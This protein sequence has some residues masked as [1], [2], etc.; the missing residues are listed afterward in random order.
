MSEMDIKGCKGG[1]GIPLTSSYYIHHY[2]MIQMAWK[3]IPIVEDDDIIGYDYYC[4]KCS[5]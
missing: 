3:L 4:E 1:C 2:Q 5:R